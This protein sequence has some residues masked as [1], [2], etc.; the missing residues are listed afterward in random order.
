MQLP[1]LVEEVES[2]ARD[3]RVISDS[4]AHFIAQG[5]IAPDSPAITRFFHF[6]D[7]PEE[8]GG[9]EGFQAEVKADIESVCSHPENFDEGPWVEDIGTAEQN[10]AMLQALWKYAGLFRAGE[11]PCT[12]G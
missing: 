8:W 3:G 6:A 7:M 12:G 1:D 10:V 2:A 9:P 5:W 11:E 4:T